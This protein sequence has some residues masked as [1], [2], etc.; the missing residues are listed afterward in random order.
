MWG[1]RTNS[2]EASQVAG[3]PAGEATS[4]LLH[5]AAAAVG[6]EQPPSRPEPC[7]SLQMHLIPPGRVSTPFSSGGLTSQRRESAFACTPT[8]YSSH[9][10]PPPVVQGRGGGGMDWSGPVPS[11]DVTATGTGAG[12]AP[13]LASR[14][15]SVQFAYPIGLVR[16]KYTLDVAAKALLCSLAGGETASF[17]ARWP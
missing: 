13:S 7:K 17:F 5:V 10:P 12:D 3:R 11:L 6:G 16:D 14:S 4:L 15:K 2:S 1:K 8:A 9:S